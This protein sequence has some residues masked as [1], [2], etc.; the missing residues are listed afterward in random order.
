MSANE[1]AHDWFAKANA[2]LT[3]AG[4]LVGISGPPETICFLAQQGAEKYLKGY[5]VW[6]RMPFQK[7][8]DLLEILNACRRVDQEFGELKED[9]L[10]LNP[11]FGRSSVSRVSWRL[12]RRRRSQCT[13]QRRAHT[14][15]CP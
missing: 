6:Q 10:I 2:D 12:H 5:L 7:V 14:C 13:G 4:L 1:H 8:H 15:I 9:C 11:L 3:S